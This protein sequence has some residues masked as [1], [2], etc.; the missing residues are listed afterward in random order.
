MRHIAPKDAT[1][2][3][4]IET[5]EWLDSLDYV[6][7]S[8]GPGKGQR[9]L[10]E[11]TL[12]AAQNGV[13]LPFPANTPYINTIPADAEVVMPGDAAIEQRIKSYVRW[14]AAAMVVRANKV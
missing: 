9:L 11:L 7:Q 6:L 10:Q 2:L 5:R 14:N 4:A 1:E 12:P 8:G 13:A 3:D